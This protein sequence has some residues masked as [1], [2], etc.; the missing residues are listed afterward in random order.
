[1]PDFIP[2]LRLSELFYREAVGPLLDSH[3]P[4]LPH[5]AALIGFGSDVIGLDTEM[6]TDHCWGPRLVLFLREEDNPRLSPQVDAALRQH[7]PLSFYGYST[8]YSAP[9]QIPG[10]LGTY[11]QQPIQSGPVNHAVEIVTLSGYLRAY[12]GIDPRG[13]VGLRDWLTFEEHR[14]LAVTSGGVFRD[15]LGL[16]AVRCKLAY[17]P[18]DVWLYILAAQWSKVDQEQPFVGRAGSVGDDL[19]SRILTARLCQYVMHVWF[20]M[21]RHYRPYSKWFGSAFLRL[22]GSAELAPLLGAALRAETWQER[23]QHLA[24]AYQRAAEAHNALGLTPP[25]D[26]SIGDF[27]DRP[28][29]VVGAGAIAAALL[30]AVEDADVRALPAGVGSVNQFVDAVD[31]IDRVDLARRLGAVFG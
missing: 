8:N 7:L 4:G 20:L 2:G 3:F 10:D 19:G 24:D 30:A 28:F 22:P 31:V 27:F 15:D 12:L 11:W 16:E 5:S 14:L 9:S 6:S 25:Q 26:T 21:A 17:Y 23:Q 1:M 13:E 29:R 18:R